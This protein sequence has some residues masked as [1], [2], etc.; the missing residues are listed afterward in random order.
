MESQNLSL[1]NFWKKLT[2]RLSKRGRRL[3]SGLA[4]EGLHAGADEVTC[5]L[6]N[7]I[8]PYQEE[9]QKTEKQL[10]LDQA[11]AIIE[12]RVARFRPPRP[13]FMQCRT[14]I[15]TVLS[16]DEEDGYHVNIINSG[17]I[18]WEIHF[19]T[20]AVQRD[21][22]PDQVDTLVVD[23]DDDE[24]TQPSISIAAPETVVMEPAAKIR[25]RPRATEYQRP[26][27]G[28]TVL[29]PI[30]SPQVMQGPHVDEEREPAKEDP[31]G[32]TFSHLPLS[33]NSMRY[34][35]PRKLFIQRQLKELTNLNC[36]P[37]IEAEEQNVIIDTDTGPLHLSWVAEKVVNGV[38][39]WCVK[40]DMGT[41]ELFI[42][43]SH[44]NVEK[45]KG[46][47][48]ERFLDDL[49]R[50]QVAYASI[51][52]PHLGPVILRYREHS[53]DMGL[54]SD[55]PDD[56]GLVADI[57]PIAGDAAQYFRLFVQTNALQ[58]VAA[59][60]KL[61]I[62]HHVEYISGPYPLIPPQPLLRNLD[63]D[64]VTGNIIRL[65]NSHE[66]QS[67]P[68]EIAAQC[69]LNLSAKAQAKYQH[70]LKR[71]FFG[72]HMRR[73]M[74]S[75]P[76]LDQLMFNPALEIVAKLVDLQDLKDEIKYARWEAK[77]FGLLSRPLENR[78][79]GR[80]ATII[81]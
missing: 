61:C 43:G 62:D 70:S 3:V 41:D 20:E 42:V 58:S 51:T 22:C 75:E 18:G 29:D 37:S 4:H 46:R 59:I 6:E 24:K 49:A 30:P 64:P 32:R 27:K 66:M 44:G 78:L 47:K 63:V 65:S 38:P 28:L 48:K 35:I 33:R 10:K 73:R 56:Q 14:L 5:E 71:H 76:R 77:M 69:P 67:V 80:M 40:S 60:S 2:R 52:S 68:W 36:I 54:L 19:W 1:I 12:D 13:G 81:E 50:I 55:L 34:T 16:V 45:L 53:S 21:E 11:V 9:A 31:D 25:E 72:V 79:K 23:G 17:L 7:H 8:P 57:V 74:A 15:T 39:V 26:Q